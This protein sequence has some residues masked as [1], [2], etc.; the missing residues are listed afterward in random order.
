[1]QGTIS[2]A[3]SPRATT[4]SSTED[5]LERLLEQLR[6]DKEAQARWEKLFAEFSASEISGRQA[7]VA[8]KSW[9]EATLSS[10]NKARFRFGQPTAPL[11]ADT[12]VL[13]RETVK[14]G[15]DTAL[16]K[17]TTCIVLG[18]EGVGKS[19]I[20]AKVAFEFGGLSLILGAEKFEGVNAAELGD[21]LTARVRHSN[22]ACSRKPYA[23]E[24]QADRVGSQ[25][26]L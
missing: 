6:I 20:A 4:A 23:L 2:R 25:A 24:A 22:K 13:A 21:L 15:I 18:T 11:Q 10:Q 17:S 14:H 5:E 12:P 1:M 16:G 7:I 8:N 19:W 3:G 9:L 26:A